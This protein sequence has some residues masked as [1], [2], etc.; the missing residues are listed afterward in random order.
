VVEHETTMMLA[1]KRMTAMLG[2]WWQRPLALPGGERGAPALLVILAVALLAQ[3][4]LVDGLAMAGFVVGRPIGAGTFFLGT[5][6]ALGLAVTLVHRQRDRLAAR[7]A[8][9]GLALLV[10]AVVAMTVLAGLVYD[11][12]WDGQG[13]HLPAIIRLASW[14]NPLTEP[15]PADAEAPVPLAYYPKAT[16][17]YGAALAAATG[18][19]EASK[20]VNL[21]L[22]LAAALLLLA[23]VARG[24]S[25]PTRGRLVIVAIAA[26]NPVVTKQLMTHYVDGALGSSLLALAAALLLTRERRDWA[27]LTALALALM[28]LATIKQTGPVFGVLLVGGFLGW[29]AWRRRPWRRPAMVAA[30]A[31]ALGVGAL[32]YHPYVQN[33]L[34]TGNPIYPF[35]GSGAAMD[36]QRP[37]NLHGAN[38]LT[39]LA[40]G[41]FG[42]ARYRQGAPAELKFPLWISPGEVVA[43]AAVDTRVGGFGPL[44]G[45]VALVALA[46]AATLRRQRPDKGMV[47]IAGLFLISGVL[48]PEPWWTRFVPQLWLVPGFLLLAVPPQPKNR[49]RAWLGAALVALM[50]FNALASWGANA[51]LIALR[52]V[53]LRRGL[54]TLAA[55]GRPVA[56]AAYFPETTK[57]RLGERGIPY[58]LVAEVH[59]GRPIRL[60]KTI[61]CPT[62]R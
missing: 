60:V 34:A 40:Y 18:S 56:V 44:S 21:V 37:A 43:M 54:S 32:G 13:Y 33:A 46:Y 47:V 50:A 6:L 15:L 8:Y 61:A 10:A 28:A 3:V 5:A 26:A 1:A 35:D 27:A 53:E 39:K 38:R 52:N 41:L 24:E 57:A 29:R 11:V 58:R 19:L 45:L 59:C 51:G 55:L 16:W 22:A 25:P 49:G 48:F 2:R 17:L 4:V 62:E 36:R 9:A 14:W 42:E 30:L 20:A 31:L 23:V 7:T 12:S